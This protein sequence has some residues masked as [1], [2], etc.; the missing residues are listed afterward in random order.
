MNLTSIYC[1]WSPFDRATIIIRHLILAINAWSV[2]SKDILLCEIFYASSKWVELS[3]QF[4][5]TA[6]LLHRTWEE[7]NNGNGN[8]PW[9]Y[10]IVRVACDRLKILYSVYIGIT[11]VVSVLWSLCI[12][13][14]K[15]FNSLQLFFSP[16]KT[17]Q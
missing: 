2:T 17:P 6:V 8:K 12:G 5:D 4:W 10:L 16:D 1:I 9:N 15:C 11:R 7:N 13:S 14:M 3:S